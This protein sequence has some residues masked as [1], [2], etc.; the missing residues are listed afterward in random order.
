MT[1]S[2]LLD[3]DDLEVKRA[4]LVDLLMFEEPGDS[5]ADDLDIQRRSKD[6][7]SF[8]C[9]YSQERLWFIEQLQLSGAAYHM[10]MA[11]R[12]QG[13]L[14]VAA[15][16]RC[17]TELVRRHESLRTHFESREGSAMQI[18]EPA[19]E[20]ALALRDLSPLSEREC[21]EQFEQLCQAE[22]QRRFDLNRGPLFRGTLLKLADR[23]HVLLLRM[24]H[25]IAD[26]WSTGILVRELSALYR[27][28]RQGLASPL[29]V[30]TGRTLRTPA[31]ILEGTADGCAVCTRLADGS[32]ATRH[33]KLQRRSSQ[34]SLRSAVAE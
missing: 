18:V 17:L 14:D 8:P 10:P 26:G 22:S 33:S 11:L 31:E 30:V 24:H 19:S 3:S 16:K 9:S 21:T 15:L 2:T 25:I 12:L 28:Y 1:S 13:E 6:A 20:F 23:E 29:P 27:A 34:R 32:S 5:L 7:S 4:E